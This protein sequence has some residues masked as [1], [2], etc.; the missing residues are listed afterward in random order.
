MP[1][2]TGPIP[3]QTCSPPSLVV[4]TLYLQQS[5]LSSNIEDYIYFYVPPPVYA[6]TA[7][8]SDK[9]DKFLFC[10]AANFNLANKF[11]AT[12]HKSNFDNRPVL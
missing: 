8:L 9:S 5:T 1:T 6:K 12:L 4:G 10:L 11:P 7:G 2:P 3:K